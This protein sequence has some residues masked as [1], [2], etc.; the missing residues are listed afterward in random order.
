MIWQT[1]ISFQNQSKIIIEEINL[2]TIQAHTFIKD[3]DLAYAAADL[4]VSRAGAIAISELCCVGKPIILVP[5]PNV[6][7]NHQY[8]NAQSLVNK[9]AALLVED[10]NASRKLVNTLMELVEDKILQGVLASNI[11]KIAVKDAADKIAEI[12]LSLIK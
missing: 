10:K 11:K 6:S 3:M 8:R 1:G 2:P 12:A 5:S 9:N 4:I 7:E